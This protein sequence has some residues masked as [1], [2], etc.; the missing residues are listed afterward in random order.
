MSNDGIVMAYI[1]GQTLPEEVGQIELA[2]FINPAG[3]T[4]LGQNLYV[5]TIASG[6][7]LRGEAG[8][9]GFGMI[10]Q[11]Y[12]ESSNVS[13]VKEMVEMITTQR[14]YEVNSKSIR[15]ASE[16]LNQAVNLKR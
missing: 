15:T 10:E 1:T 16:M 11:G 9:E 4:S 7:P 3:L 5:E 14:A 2:R 12:L 6:P 8:M 13:V